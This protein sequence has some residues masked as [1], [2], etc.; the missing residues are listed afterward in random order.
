M[1]LNT[2]TKGIDKV[3]LQALGLVCV[4]VVIMVG[5]R[6]V[7]ARQQADVIRDLLLGNARGIVAHTVADVAAEPPTPM[8][9]ADFLTDIVS[10]SEHHR[11]GLLMQDGHVLQALAQAPG[12][13][14]PRWRELLAGPGIHDGSYLDANGTLVPAPGNFDYMPEAVVLDVAGPGARQVRLLVSMQTARREQGYLFQQAVSSALV[15]CVF[16]LAFL[17]WVLRTPR[18]SLSAASRYAAA[19]PQGTQQRLPIIDSHIDAIDELRESLNQVADVLEQ[20]RVRQ[21]QHDAALQEAVRAARSATEAKSAF[22]ANISHEIRTPLNGMLGLTELL[23]GGELSPQQRH[24]L[25]LSRQSSRQLLA[26]VNDVLDLSKVEAHQMTLESVPFSLYELLD[27]MVPLFAV[28]AADK[29]LGLFNQVCPN[30][31]L[32]VVGDPLRLR[33]VIDN[34]IGNAVKFTRSGH[35]RLYVEGTVPSSELG[36]A[37]H[38]TLRFEVADTGPGI[39]PERHAAVLQA[40]GQADASTAREHGGTGLGLTIS[41]ALL[42]LMGSQLLIESAPGC[43]STFSFELTF[44]LSAAPGTRALT[45]YSHWPGL[46]ALWIDPEP[47]S[48]AWFGH[49]LS[50]WDVQVTGATTLAEARGLL[51]LRGADTNIVFI[52]GSLLHDADEGVVAGLLAEQRGARI[53]SMLGPR[54]RLSAGLQ[55]PHDG[56]LTLMKPIS[57]RSLNQALAASPRAP[58]GDALPARP[59]SLAGLRVLLAE[60]N[61]VNVIVAT[62]MLAR[63]GARVEHVPGGEQAVQRARDEHF[64]LVLMDLQMPGMNGH[65]ACEALRA[66]E[67]AQGRARVPVIAMTA[68]LF[69]HEHAHIESSGMDGYIGKPFMAADLERE[70]TRVLELAQG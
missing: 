44:P 47:A 1:R 69:E 32:V 58:R 70:I 40:F 24:Y 39:A 14:L 19:L 64:D 10:L 9:D 60:D 57:P 45:R 6:W 67:R 25:Q 61:D 56:L 12:L 4:A 28:R 33:Q 31:P 38:V 2:S 34:L 29:G 5:N 54:D 21:Q 68:H 30:L 53:V 26:I 11:V 66:A 17:W 7:V 43:G 18:R 35:V 3:L 8:G 27:E 63:L 55:A 48:R 15:M 49:V 22:V 13:D 59:G 51:A 42:Q 62:A 37:D 41:A 36:T 46:R 50:L 65:V 52:C 16:V 20:Q 23:L